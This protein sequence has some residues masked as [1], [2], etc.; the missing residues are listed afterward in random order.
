MNLGE[1]LQKLREEKKMSREELAGEMNVSRQAV[2][3]WE[4]NKGYPD[5]ENLIKLSELYNVMLDELIKGDQSF[6]SKIAIDRKKSEDFSDPGFV[7]GIILVFAGLF[8]DLGKFSAGVT[9]LGFLTMF[10]YEDLMRTFWSIKR[11]FQE[12]R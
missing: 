2:Y 8:L 11:V 7:V 9:I 1:Q 4:N 10:F 5:I 6:Q 3:K 12:G